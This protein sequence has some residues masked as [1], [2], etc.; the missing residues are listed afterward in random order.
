MMMKMGG[1]IKKYIKRMKIEVVLILFYLKNQ[2]KFLFFIFCS[3]EKKTKKNNRK[4]KKKR[5][6]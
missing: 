2:F 6:K 4:K 1:K 3:P 5:Y